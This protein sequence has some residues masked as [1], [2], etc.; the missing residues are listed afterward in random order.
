MPVPFS[1][2]SARV[3]DTT[4]SST[5]NNAVESDA[6]HAH[7]QA[8]YVKVADVTSDRTDVVN[9]GTTIPNSNA[10]SQKLVHEYMTIAEIGSNYATIYGNASN[11]FAAS[12]LTADKLTLSGTREVRANGGALKLVVGNS[13]NLP[14]LQTTN[15]ISGTAKSVYLQPGLGTNG[16]IV[17]NHNIEFFQDSENKTTISAPDEIILNAKQANDHKLTL[18]CP[19]A[20]AATGAG[21]LVSTEPFTAPSLTASDSLIYG[22]DSQTSPPIALQ[23]KNALET[24]TT[25]LMRLAPF[26]TGTYRLDPEYNHVKFRTFNGSKDIMLRG[27]N[28]AYL[29]GGSAT[30]A[31]AARITL[32][33]L[34]NAPRVDIEGAVVANSTITCTSLTQTSD[35]R[36]KRNLAPIHGALATI[37]KL[38]PQT[39]DKQGHAD[40]GFVAQEIETIPEL[41]PYVST[42]EDEAPK[43]LN[44]SA[45]F[46]HAVAALQELDSVVQRQASTITALAARISALESR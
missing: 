14:N 9:G 35:R 42:P 6:L 20:S 43:G 8:T 10:V 13:D 27:E 28:R 12:A 39:Y 38:S 19:S 2:L 22:G 1:D 36:L 46:S 16:A 41:K 4:L 40:A 33:R 45:L 30:W 32:Q 34:S 26:N 21:S 25:D 31:N 7:L 5:S 11:N 15:L 29:V 23:I 24:N 18:T 44:Y 17:S 3:I 37:R